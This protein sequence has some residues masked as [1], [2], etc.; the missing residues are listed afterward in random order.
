[1]RFENHGFDHI[2]VAVKD[3]GHYANMYARMGFE[4]IGENQS[5]KRGR[6]G[7]LWG[8]GHI[9]I[10]LTSYENDSKET[11]AE[12]FRSHGDGIP[13]LALDVKDVNEA[14]ELA[15]QK[16][17]RIAKEPVTYESDEGKITRAEI[18][19]PGDLRW[20]FVKREGRLFDEDFVM[21]K[22]E[23]PSPCNLIKVDH[24]TNNV[25]IGDMSQWTEWY[26]KIFNFKVIRH[27]DITT[28]KTGLISDA[29]RSQC[30]KIT[31]PINEAKEPESQVQEF[32]NRFK[33]AG[34][35]HLAFLTSDIIDSLKQLR[36]KDFRFLDVPDTYYEMVP[37]RVPVFDEDL[38]ELKELK[39]LLDSEGK[40]YLL[41]IF[42]H[43]VMG[44]FFFEFIQRK[45]NDGFGE[46]NFK[47]LF[48][49]IE[50]DQE[51]RGVL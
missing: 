10:F 43:E 3:L 20:A 47:A 4:K 38:E 33:G 11:S 45:G 40:G 9:R 14:F 5:S 12:F 41:Q 15:T 39:I 28:G 49:A 8:Q 13:V 19:T 50:L 2:E 51:R 21:N 26:Q 42:T 48:R 29:V 22:L 44:P 18:Y 34:V 37:K 23:S 17:A 16:G 35:Q 27:F 7:E 31:V 46:G 25:N 6:R 36:G 30:G 32:V 24:L 1:M